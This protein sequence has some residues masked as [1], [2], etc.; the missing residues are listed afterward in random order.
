MVFA[1]QVAKLLIASSDPHL[2]RLIKTTL[3][4][5]CVR[6]DVPAAL[7]HIT[8]G[9]SVVLKG[10]I[11]MS[12]DLVLDLP[13]THYAEPRNCFTSTTQII[14]LGDDN[15]SNCPLAKAI[16]KTSLRKFACVPICLNSTLIGI[17]HALTHELKKFSDS[18]L[19]FMKARGKRLALAFHHITYF[20]NMGYEWVSF[21]RSQSQVKNRHKVWATAGL[22]EQKD[23]PK[24]LIDRVLALEGLNSTLPVS[25]LTQS[26][27]KGINLPTLRNVCNF[28]ERHPQA[29]S[30]RSLAQALR[31]SE[32]TAGHYLTYL[33]NLGIVD[34]K[35]VYGKPGRP[36]LVYSVEKY[37]SEQPG[38]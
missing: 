2:L 12:D 11:I 14:K 3:E 17:F 31:F 27:P 7:L 38:K 36:P 24:L 15:S 21:A 19:N 18:D 13:F 1:N 9:S 23:V 25:T 16:E 28:L 30:R 20:P 5:I 29:L 37:A 6:I 4:E 10:K 34:K 35:M 32:I 8:D 33:T 22:E 26:L